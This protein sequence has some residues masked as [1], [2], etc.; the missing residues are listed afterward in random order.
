MYPVHQIG[1]SSYFISNLISS[2]SPSP[3]LSPISSLS[4]LSW[5]SSSSDLQNLKMRRVL[6]LCP[7]LR[8]VLR[9]PF[10]SHLS[11][12][13]CSST[14]YYVL[15]NIKAHMLYCTSKDVINI[16]SNLHW[17]KVYNVILRVGQVF[18]HWRRSRPLSRS[19]PFQ[20]STV[21]Y[22]DLQGSTGIYW[23]LLGSTGIYH[24]AEGY[25]CNS[26]SDTIT[27]FS[28]I[29]VFAILNIFPKKNFRHD[30]ANY[31]KQIDTRCNV[32]DIQ[33]AG[34]FVNLDLLFCQ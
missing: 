24:T 12:Q 18:P 22:R 5:L 25:F 10:S 27:H 26:A 20:W 2:W 9:S 34:N 13:L 31:V 19:A 29:S 23:D 4:S 16:T 33:T 7:F 11:S 28:G 1:K 3:S 17:C 15:P 21:V 30:D 8:P 32:A 6:S 14:T